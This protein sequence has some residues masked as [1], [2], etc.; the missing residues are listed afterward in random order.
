MRGRS[1]PMCGL[2]RSRVCSAPLARLNLHVSKPA[3]ARAALRPGQASKRQIAVRS[4]HSGLSFSIRSNFPGSSPALQNAL[5][6]RASR[7]DEY[8]S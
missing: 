6:I 7:I 4:R 2:W 5:S 8:S 1:T 3:R